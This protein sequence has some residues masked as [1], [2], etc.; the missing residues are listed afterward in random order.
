MAWAQRPPETLPTD[1][2]EHIVLS[3][4][5]SSPPPD[6]VLLPEKTVLG[7]SSDSSDGYG[8]IYI[9]CA[10]NSDPSLGRCPVVDTGENGG[11]TST[12]SLQFVEQRSNLR[13]NVK[14]RGHLLR[15]DSTRLCSSGYWD[16]IERPL[17][18]SDVG[19]CEGIPPSGTGG[20]LAVDA[21]EMAKLVAGHWK[22][23]LRLTLHAGVSGG[24]AG[25]LYTIKYTFDLTITDRANAS[26]Y[27]PLWDEASPLVGLN[28]AY[29]PVGMPTIGGHASLDMCL[30]D[31]LGS[32]SP[33]L[34]V[35]IDDRAP[36]VPGRLPGMYSVW[37]D[38]GI[39]DAQHRLDYEITLDYGGAPVV[40]GNGAMRTLNGIDTA[41][42]R[43]VVLP[44]MTQPVYCVPT[45]LVL[46]TPAV[47]ASSKAEGHYQGVLHIE[48]NIPTGSP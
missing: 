7:Y 25:A 32:Q 14:V 1:R 27:F 43:L 48:M 46:V 16:S 44:G 41:A 34:E 45:P 42:L 28:I 20:E 26:I 4:D 31:G 35:T 18:S 11:N 38:N 30:Y 23:E 19:M 17:W 39:Q 22:A 40:M 29:S 9:T 36:P 13:T 15:I 5:R 12:I 47:P 3:Y 8:R 33:Y 37:H 10:S 21:D 24:G 6:Q 2:S